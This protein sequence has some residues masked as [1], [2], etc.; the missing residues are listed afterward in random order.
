MLLFMNFYLNILNNYLS[1]KINSF[2]NYIDEI[3]LF[4]FQFGSGK[5][6]MF[7]N[8]NFIIFELS[9]V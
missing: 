1:C 3:N 7:L 9:P 2:P 8:Q 5:K 6:I 4:E